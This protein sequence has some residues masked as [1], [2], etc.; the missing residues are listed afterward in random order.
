MRAMKSRADG[1]FV[2]SGDSPEVVLFPGAFTYL[3]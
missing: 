2:I 1:I 3:E